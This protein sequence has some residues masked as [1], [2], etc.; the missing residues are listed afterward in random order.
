[1]PKAASDQDGSSADR[2]DLVQL[3]TLAVTADGEP[4]AKVVRI[5]DGEAGLAARTTQPRMATVVG[6]VLENCAIAS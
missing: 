3:V 5:R 2:P 4:D 6:L 1:M